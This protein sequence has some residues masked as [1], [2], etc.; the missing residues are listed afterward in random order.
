MYINPT[1]ALSQV[2]ACPQPDMVAVSAGEL[3]RPW[4]SFMLSAIIEEVH[5]VESLLVWVID[6]KEPPGF[7]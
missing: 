4:W 3:L 5:P 7:V 1:S 2:S 6:Y